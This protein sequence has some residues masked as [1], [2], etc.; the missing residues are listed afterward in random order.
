MGYTPEPHLSATSRG[1]WPHGLG[2]CDCTGMQQPLSRT[3]ETRMASAP[4]TTIAAHFQADG[5]SPA[6]GIGDTGHGTGPASRQGDDQ[7]PAGRQ[8]TAATGGATPFLDPPAAVV[9]SR[10]PTSRWYSYPGRPDQAARV[11]AFLARVLAGCPAA[12][13]VILMADELVTNA[14]QHTKSREPGG[15]FGVRVLVCHG[16][17]VRVEVADAG[18]RWARPGSVDSSGC[19]GAADGYR[20]GGRGLHIVE[21]LSAA[22]GVAGDQAGRTVWFTAPWDAG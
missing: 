18:G 7:S 8:Q 6:S 11:R 1:R 12:E 20:P 9:T 19:D 22:W 17:W 4:Q 13:D 21:V 10:P 5:G 14:L 2:L 16:E 15:T 3:E